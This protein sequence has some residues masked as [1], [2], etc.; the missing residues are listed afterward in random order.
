MSI[1]KC[2]FGCVAPKRYPGCHAQCP[3]YCAE[4]AEHERIM[5]QDFER[6]KVKN[7]I[8]NQRSMH[9]AKA[10]KSHMRKNMGN[11][12]KLDYADRKI[13]IAYAENNMRAKWAAKQLG[14][15]WNLVYRRLDK[16]F[17]KTGLDPRN[18]Y[19]LHELVQMAKEAKSE[20]A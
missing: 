16:I 19:D 11:A 1:I 17:D 15:Y 6:R 13:I 5:A 2:C 12:Y 3:E 9:V 8:Y 4:K 20:Q 7:D 10:L 14:V 18:F